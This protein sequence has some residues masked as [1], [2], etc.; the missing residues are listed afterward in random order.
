MLLDNVVIQKWNSK[1]KEW[2]IN[3]GYKYTKMKDEFVCNVY[4]LK[5]GSNIY[6]NVKCDYCGKEYKIKWCNRIKSVTNCI[7]HKDACIDCCNKKN[8]DIIKKKYNVDNIMNVSEFKNRL[9]K[10]IY[11]KYGVKN[12]FS[13]NKIK[14]KIKETN[15][16]KYGVEN[17]MYSDN[18]K[19]KLKETNMKKYGCECVFQSE[20]IKE[21][22][23]STNMEKYG[24]DNYM[25]YAKVNELYRGEKSSHWKPIK[26]VIS[27]WNSDYITWRNYILERDNYTC[28]CCNSTKC[29]LEAHHINNW[30]DNPDIRY[31]IC[32]G[33]TLCY[34][35][36]KL[37]HSIYTRFNNNISQLNEFIDKYGKKIC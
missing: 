6:V 25:K 24:F 4:D 21:K 11:E 19:N 8:N 9:E 22:I 23:K 27:R 20:E 3:K 12:V 33:I 32:N 18:I 36:H 31:D 17:P 26:K 34:D 10:S 16:Y 14:E 30:K 13:S 7:V 28:Q 35:C 2:Y 29:K 5:D 37:F 1:N 15:L